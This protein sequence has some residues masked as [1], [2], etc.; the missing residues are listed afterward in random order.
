MGSF[1]ETYIDPKKQTVIFV[2]KQNRIRVD[3]APKISCAGEISVDFVFNSPPLNIF[4]RFFSNKKHHDSWLILKESSSFTRCKI[5]TVLFCFSE[6]VSYLME[7][8]GVIV[9]QLLQCIYVVV[10]FYPWFEFSFLLSQTHY[11]ALPYPKTK[12]NK[13]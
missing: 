12:E 5:F 11:H 13:I 8:S 7:I 4:L 9:G 1:P 6:K 3:G 10:Q 2:F